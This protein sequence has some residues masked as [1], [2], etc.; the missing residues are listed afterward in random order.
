M[1]LCLINYRKWEFVLFFRVALGIVVM[2]MRK[3]ENGVDGVNDISIKSTSISLSHWD[4][5]YYTRRGI[6]YG[7][8][9][10]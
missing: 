2:A 3:I 10:C 8:L 6:P 1:V 4:E 7:W 5:Q 9:M